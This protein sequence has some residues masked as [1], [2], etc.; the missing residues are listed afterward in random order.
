MWETKPKFE[1][2]MDVDLWEKRTDPVKYWGERWLK[3]VWVDPEFWTTYE[4][5]KW[6]DAIEFLLRNK[7]GQVL[8]AFTD[9][10]WNPV[11]I[12]RWRR[13]KK[14]NWKT[15]AGYWISKIK[16][17]H[18]DMLDNVQELIDRSPRYDEPNDRVRYYNEDTGEW[19]VI[20]K[21]RWQGE[22]MREKRHILTMYTE[23]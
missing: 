3:E 8:W 20:T 17:K 4:W 19:V 1:I 18:A 13:E 23:D 22:N 14:V 2:R 7:E 5:I 10:N 9:Q 11:D 16:Q 21:T 15:I 6:Q 12:V